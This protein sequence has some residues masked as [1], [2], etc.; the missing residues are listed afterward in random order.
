[1]SFICQKTLNS[2]KN[3]N[4]APHLPIYSCFVIMRDFMMSLSDDQQADIISALNT[5]SR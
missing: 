3:T 2:D 4:C 1:M 5:T